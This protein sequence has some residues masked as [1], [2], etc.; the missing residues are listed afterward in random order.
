MRDRSDYFNVILRFG[1]VPQAGLAAEVARLGTNAVTRSELV[2][3][4]REN[5]PH[6]GKVIE[7]DEQLAQ[8]LESWREADELL[9]DYESFLTQRGL[10]VW[11]KDSRMAQSMRERLKHDVAPDLP[12][13]PWA[14][15]CGLLI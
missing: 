10:R 5:A 15:A 2:A 8:L 9:P 6:E 12:P 14:P 7:N 13:C 3:R 1:D 11:H 4:L